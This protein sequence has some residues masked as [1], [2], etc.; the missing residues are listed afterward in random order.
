MGLGYVVVAVFVTSYVTIGGKVIYGYV[1]AYIKI[2]T[3]KVKDMIVKILNK[4]YNIK[5]K[6]DYKKFQQA[7]KNINNEFSK[8][9]I[10]QY[11]SDPNYKINKNGSIVKRDFFDVQMEYIY[12]V[13]AAVNPFAHPF[14]W[15]LL[16]GGLIGN[17]FKI[18]KGVMNE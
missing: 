5:N 18:E 13:I 12:R 8:I 15:G 2:K 3:K 7:L 14:Y 16:L 4:E 1:K 17:N 11:C 9:K 6:K 10:V